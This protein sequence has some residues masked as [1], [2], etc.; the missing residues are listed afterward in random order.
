MNPKVFI[1]GL[2]LVLSLLFELVTEYKGFPAFQIGF[3]LISDQR[4]T[5][6][7]YAYFVL[8]HLTWIGLSFALCLGER[9]YLKPLLAFL[10]IQIA[11]LFDFCL[12]YNEV[13]F[14]FLGLPI[15]MN[16]VGVCIFGY[17]ALKYGR[18]DS[19]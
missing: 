16:T 8:E 5:F 9:R 15:S 11:H 19:N 10:V 2:L 3:P 18:I 1:A 4:L 6:Q 13:W 12:T 17:Y 7:T 14:H